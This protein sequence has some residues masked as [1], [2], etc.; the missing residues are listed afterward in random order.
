LQ[1]WQIS[2]SLGVRPV[3]KPSTVNPLTYTSSRSLPTVRR[4]ACDP[5]QDD[6]TSSKHFPAAVCGGLS[7]AVPIAKKSA[8]N[9]PSSVKRLPMNSLQGI[10]LQD[11]SLRG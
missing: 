6:T 9:F 8:Q 3:L 4:I 7:V 10:P 5:V 1:G 2:S 11:T